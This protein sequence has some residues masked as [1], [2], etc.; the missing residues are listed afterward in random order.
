M[1]KLLDLQ[2]FLVG[3]IYKHMSRLFSIGPWLMELFNPPPRESMTL[4][5]KG[6]RVML[7]T[8]TLVTLCIFS[9]LVLALGFFVVQ[10]SHEVLVGIPQLMNVL[11]IL[12]VSI[13]M[14]ILC[15]KVLF[16][17]RRLDRRLIPERADFQEIEVPLP[18][19]VGTTSAKA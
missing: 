12:F 1:A 15:V 17:I 2:N 7:V 9:S 8:V 6:G 18:P 10:R 5:Q 19:R 14:N 16:T 3:R 4:L 11:T 13:G